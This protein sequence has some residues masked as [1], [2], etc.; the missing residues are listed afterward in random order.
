MTLIEVTVSIVI[1]GL[2]GTA[3]VGT[4]SYLSGTGN[5]SMLQ[6]QAQSIANAYLQE[7]AGKPFVDPNVT[8]ETVRAQF[9]DILDYNGLDTPTASDELGNV[10]GN[11]RVRV[12]VVPGALNGLPPANVRR[13]DVT[14]DYGNGAR[15]IASGYRTNYP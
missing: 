6:A 4:L 3:L 12:S 2:A 13:I 7:I 14:V 9:D 8:G 5:T 15:V 1:I 11:F 10:A